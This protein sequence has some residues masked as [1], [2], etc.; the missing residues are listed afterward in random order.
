MLTIINVIL[1][2]VFDVEIW[3]LDS[4]YGLHSKQ[5]LALDDLTILHNQIDLGVFWIYSF[6]R[7]SYEEHNLDHNLFHKTSIDEALKALK[8]LP[9]KYREGGR[10]FESLRMV[11]MACM[12]FISESFQ[13]RRPSRFRS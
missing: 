10:G 3:N 7:Y 4:S 2:I 1:K 11:L 8:N 12:S 6:G 5:S 13:N 9:M